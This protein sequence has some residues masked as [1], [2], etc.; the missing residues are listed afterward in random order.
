M[1]KIISVLLI[2]MMVLITALYSDQGL[3]TVSAAS[4]GSGG[5]SQ[6]PY[7]PANLALPAG[8]IL[9]A[10]S[11]KLTWQDKSNNETE[12]RIERALSGSSTWSKLASVSANGTSYQDKTVSAGTAYKY[13]VYA[14]NSY[15]YSG[16]ASNVLSVT[17]AA[18]PVV[19]V[20]QGTPSAWAAAEIEKAKLANL[21]TDRILGDYLKPITREEFCE[22]VV[23]L[24]EASTGTVAIAADPNPFTDTVNP[25]IL[26]AYQLGI[27][28]GI[29]STTFAPNSA[30]SRQEI[31]VMFMRELKAAEPD[32]DFSID[33]I[34]TFTDQSKIAGWA[35]DS[36]RYMN[37][38]G[39]MNGTGGGNISPV[40]NTTR[41]QAIVLVY[42]TFEKF[43]SESETETPS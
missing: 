7:A 36:I 27:V 3:D 42:R 37:Q 6:T 32:E 1:K 24:Y 33:T 2:A 16:S 18:V 22:A 25:E 30:I 9:E 28:K 21:T 10:N 39:V 23:K 17:T 35:L 43:G 31:A 40:S 38:E 34:T 29:T 5:S 19:V 4:G 26:K 14:Y 13:R 41:E 11:V 20:P 15:G 12:F 8:Y